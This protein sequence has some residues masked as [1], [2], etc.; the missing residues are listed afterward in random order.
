MVGRHVRCGSNSEVR[1]RNGEVGFAPKNG[2]DRPSLSGPKSAKNGS[3]DDLAASQNASLLR[4]HTA[5]RSRQKTGGQITGS[6][7]SSSL[8]MQPSAFAEY[9]HLRGVLFANA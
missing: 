5:F 2:H 8:G 9:F 3:D 4:V 7:D 6:R 1:A